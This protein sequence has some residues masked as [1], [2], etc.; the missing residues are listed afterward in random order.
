LAP[1]RKQGRVSSQKVAPGRAGC[2]DKAAGAPGQR[3]FAREKNDA[4]KSKRWI[5]D[6]FASRIPADRDLDFYLS[7]GTKALVKQMDRLSYPKWYKENAPFLTCDKDGRLMVDV[8]AKEFA[9]PFDK[10]DFF[11]KTIAKLRDSASAPKARELLRRYAPDG[12]AA[13]SA[14]EWTRWWDTNRPY[15]FYSEGGGYRWYIDPL[16]KH[17]GIPS[18]KLKGPARATVN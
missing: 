4:P 6:L 9:M 14:E 2:L 11:P 13:G 12:P 8:N 3:R 15:L 7:P 18:D 10:A 1:V 16:A 17:R 5:E